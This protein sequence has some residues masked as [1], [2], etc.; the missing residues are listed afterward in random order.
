MYEIWPTSLNRIIPLY[1]HKQSNNYSEPIDG[2]SRCSRAYENIE[3]S[4]MIEKF[5]IWIWHSQISLCSQCK[6]YSG[7]PRFSTLFRVCFYAIHFGICALIIPAAMVSLNNQT[8]WFLGRAGETRGWKDQWGF[9]RSEIN[10]TI[11]TLSAQSS[12]GTPS[13]SPSLWLSLSPSLAV[14]SIFPG[15][16]WQSLYLKH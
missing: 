15:K 3:N 7:N 12:K 14:E 13:S 1:W 2:E 16:S 6:L 9:Y 10:G 11:N 4:S 8:G 5:P